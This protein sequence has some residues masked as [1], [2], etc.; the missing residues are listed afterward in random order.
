MFRQAN[1]ERV[2]P[3]I[4]DRLCTQREQVLGKIKASWSQVSVKYHAA[5]LFL[6]CFVLFNFLLLIFFGS[7]PHTICFHVESGTHSTDQPWRARLLIPVMLRYRKE[8]EEEM[9]M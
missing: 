2:G 7:V 9:E 3:S 4:I 1:G 8:R 5:M 6:F